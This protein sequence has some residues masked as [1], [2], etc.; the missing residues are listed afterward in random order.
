MVGL[1]LTWMVIA[2][3]W[4]VIGGGLLVSSLR[5]GGII[6]GFSH[7]LLS[8]VALALATAWFGS[9][10]DEDSFGW[11][12]LLCGVA[13]FSAW[14]GWRIHRR[15][16]V[17]DLL[18]ATDPVPL[19]SDPPAPSP[20]PFL[21]SDWVDSSDADLTL[22]KYRELCDLGPDFHFMLDDRGRILSANRFA[23]KQLGCRPERLIGRRLLE[24]IPP[25]SRARAFE[26]W[27][28][29]GGAGAVEGAELSLCGVNREYCCLASAVLVPPGAGRRSRVLLV[30]QD[31]THRSWLQQKLSQTESLAATGKIAAG[32]AHE[33]KNPLQAVLIH[34]ELIEGALPVGF[35]ERASWDRVREGISRIQEIVADLLDLNRGGEPTT[36]P[37]DINKV[38][39]EVVGLVETTFMRRRVR[40]LREL[41]PNLPPVRG[42]SRHFYQ[43]VLNLLLNAVDAMSEG[44]QV[45]IR[46][47]LHS[48]SREVGFDIADTGPGIPEQMLA[49]IF[50]PFATSDPR[51]G[52]GLGLFVTYGL[53]RQHGGRIRV[54]SAP[55]KGTTFRV[56]FPAEGSGSWLPPP[57]MR[58]AGERAEH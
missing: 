45:T 10:A 25:L 49:R 7:V 14:K 33:I 28:Q 3:A 47:R 11:A 18:S 36:G 2:G 54:D 24:W 20:K 16:A 41:T 13:G 58:K 21:R 34:M 9:A 31:V 17:V 29:L 6:R 26:L 8:L 30:L 5:S 38:L 53:V 55:G 15:S 1:A 42:V 37:V 44:G 40:I 57:V 48:G 56:V 27:R 35:S 22:G 39:N 19:R 12:L 46:S 51:Q 32:V 4:I 43:V 52:T 23:F 50:D